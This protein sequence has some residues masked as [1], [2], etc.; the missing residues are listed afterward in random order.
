MCPNHPDKKVIAHGVCITCYQRE[1]RARIAAA[2]P[3]TPANQD[4]STAAPLVEALVRSPASID[5]ALTMAG[6]E[7]RLALPEAARAMRR[8]INR[9][10]PD[11]TVLRAAEAVLRGVKVPGPE[12]S[13]RLLEE[14]LRAAEGP[15]PAQVVIGLHVAG[16]DVRLGTV[17]GTVASGIQK[18]S[19]VKGRG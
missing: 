8:I 15:A 1:R 18:K 12:G 3:P 7:L 5:E 11:S 4:T 2:A 10:T 6:D 14:P 17:V 9:G 19:P 13:Q 16:S